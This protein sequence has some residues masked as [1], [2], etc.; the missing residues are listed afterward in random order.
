MSIYTKTGDKGS[1]SLYGKRVP[2]S[3]FVIE[4]LGELDELN[5]LVGS[6]AT[7]VASN[8]IYK[9]SQGFL[10]NIQRNIFAISSY[11]AGYDVSIDILKSVKEFENGIDELC[12]D[13]KPLKNFIL[14]GGS[15]KIIQANL[16]RVKTR[17]IEVL[18]VKA[19]EQED[20]FCNK[21]KHILPFFNRL[22]DYF[23]AFGLF[24]AEKEN[25]ELT[26]WKLN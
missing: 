17:K 19:L 24:I 1:T 23:F 16:A 5:V 4:L 12:K 7:S 6:L 8:N 14:P 2:K 9:E 11:L 21:N 3:F 25:I 13:T 18:F 26:K 10:I 22:S 15:S 20:T